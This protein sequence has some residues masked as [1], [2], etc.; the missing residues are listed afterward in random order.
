MDALRTLVRLKRQGEAERFKATFK[1]LTEH[2]FFQNGQV[3]VDQRTYQEL[4]DS[5][6]EHRRSIKQHRATPTL[7]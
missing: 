5:L 4:R 1:E 3:F 6:A 2:V 7:P